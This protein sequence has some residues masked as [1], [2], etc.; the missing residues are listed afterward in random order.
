L[1]IDNITIHYIILLLNVVKYSS[2]FCVI[3]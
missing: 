1:A 3:L 2:V